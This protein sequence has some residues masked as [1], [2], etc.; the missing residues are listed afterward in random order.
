[1]WCVGVVCR[2]VV[3]GGVG[4]SNVQEV[5]QCVGSMVWC[6]VVW[7]EVVWGGVVWDGVVWGEQSNV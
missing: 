2:G 6:G 3:W 4:Q 1:M 5:W 7:C